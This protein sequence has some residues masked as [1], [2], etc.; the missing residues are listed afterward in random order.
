MPRPIDRRD[1][2]LMS[3]A[4]FAAQW[5]FAAPTAA[6]TGMTVPVIDRLSI[7]VLTDSS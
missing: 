6:N 2:L 3:S 5:G 4:A 7:K 1:F